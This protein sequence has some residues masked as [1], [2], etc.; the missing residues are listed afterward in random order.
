MDKHSITINFGISEK[1]YVYLSLKK[2][3]DRKDTKIIYFL[4]VYI[5]LSKLV[6]YID[7]GV[8]QSLVIAVL[9]SIALIAVPLFT[10]F[11][12]KGLFKYNKADLS[13]IKIT[14]TEDDIIKE[15]ITTRTMV[16]W[17]EINRIAE[18]KMWYCF[19]SVKNSFVYIKKNALD[20]QQRSDLILLANTKTRVSK[21]LF[22]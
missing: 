10:F 14:L 15:D 18:T 12:S 3:Y 22:K 16:K 21:K 8:Y 9:L 2:I 5:F 4:G 6:D 17:S 7:N 13:N 1:E 20:E 19:W 11:K